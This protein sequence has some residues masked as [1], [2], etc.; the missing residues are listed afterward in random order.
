MEGQAEGGDQQLAQLPPP[1]QRRPP[2]QAAYSQRPGGPG[3][4]LAV[5]EAGRRVSSMALL[6]TGPRT[7][8]FD[9]P[10]QPCPPPSHKFWSEASRPQFKSYLQPC[11]QGASHFPSLGT[12]QMGTVTT[13]SSQ[14]GC[15]F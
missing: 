5:P 13:P 11:D 14:H 9:L 7:P 4:H 6:R 15:E 8:H 2:S 3:L 1:L 12:V 10:K